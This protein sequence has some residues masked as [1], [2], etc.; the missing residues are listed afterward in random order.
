MKYKVGDKVRVRKDLVGDS[1]Y[2]TEKF[3]SDMKKYSGKIMTVDIITSTGKYNLKEDAD[4][5]NWTDEMLEEVDEMGNVKIKIAVDGNK[6]IAKM[7]KETGI[8]K[9]SPEDEFDIFTGVRL[10][11]DRLEE[12]C[13]PYGWLKKDVKYYFP[14]VDI[15]KL[16]D[17]YEYNNDDIDKRFIS[18][19][20]IF[21]TKE[22]ALVVAKKMLAVLKEDEDDDC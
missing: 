13:K 7:G 3:M 6:V 5:W 15:D 8:A 18:R 4:C 12:K 22:E 10:A 9:C 1:Q 11:I 16:Y 20:L 14:R 21:K 17:Y 2:G 19:G